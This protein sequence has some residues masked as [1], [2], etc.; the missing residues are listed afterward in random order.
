M[1]YTFC[2]YISIILCKFNFYNLTNTLICLLF[3]P[4]LCKMTKVTCHL[5]NL[6]SLN[7]NVFTIYTDEPKYRRNASVYK[8]LSFL[9]YKPSIQLQMRST[10]SHFTESSTNFGST[11]TLPL[12]LALTPTLALALTLTLTLALTLWML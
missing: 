3:E 11:T 12:T 7:L 10:A 4:V 9:S 1:G 8:K 6:T 2:P 5:Q